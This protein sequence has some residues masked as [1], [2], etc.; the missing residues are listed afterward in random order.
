MSNKNNTKIAI[1]GLGY[2]GLPLAVEFGKI[3]ET[4]GFDINETRINDLMSGK[5]ATMEISSNQL[6][7]SKNLYFSTDIAAIKNCNIFIITVPTPVDKYKKPDLKPLVQASEIV[8]TILKKEDII[9]YES[10]VYPGAT[11]EICV[12]ILEKKMSGM[13]FNKDFYCGYSRED[14]P[15]RQES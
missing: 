9:I 4:V 7:D 13:H 1:I 2:V 14:Q 11:E 3:Y 15:G 5:D 8:G 12:P 6:K 10:T